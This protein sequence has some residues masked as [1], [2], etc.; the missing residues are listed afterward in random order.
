ML[1]GV[2]TVE[3]ENFD[4]ITE[5]YKHYDL[6]YD[7]LELQNEVFTYLIKKYD[8]LPIKKDTVIISFYLNEMDYSDRVQY[9]KTM[10]SKMRKSLDDEIGSVRKRKSENG[11]Y[12]REYPQY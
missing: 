11:K 5:E 8:K 3:G 2:V 12:I 6:V 10:L 1:E 7:S 9:F 4:T